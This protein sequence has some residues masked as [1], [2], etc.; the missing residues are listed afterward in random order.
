[1]IKEMP[2]AERPREKLI[3]QGAQALTNS[4]LLA[5]IFQT[6]SRNTNVLTLAQ[7]LIKQFGNLQ[8]L[9]GADAVSFCKSHGAGIAKYAQLQACL[10]LT[11]RL[12]QEPLC[13]R[14]ALQ[15]STQTK[16]FL[17]SALKL[18]PHEV[19]AVLFLD[20]Q[21]RII[22]F[23]KLFYGTIDAATVYPR[24]IVEH[25]L[26]L[27]SCAVILSHN[28]PSGIVKPSLADKQITKRLIQA[29]GLIDVRVLDH[30]IVAGHLTYSFAE[31]GEL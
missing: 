8:A 26:Q 1:M 9:F 3:T 30:I 20:N 5:L 16:H 27:G 18:E 11:Q 4:E 28:H 22:S 21:H 2:N 23:K 17:I 15:S 12:L 29:L 14:Q 31:C 10:V 19:F 24:V 25:A 7:N 13:Q 6:G